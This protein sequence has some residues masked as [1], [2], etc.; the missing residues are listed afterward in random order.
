M[1]VYVSPN[2]IQIQKTLGLSIYF[3]SKQYA[4]LKYTVFPT[5]A[6]A[7]CLAGLPLYIL[8]FTFL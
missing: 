8:N 7:C 4:E 6:M 5:K 1:Y 2:L 3:H